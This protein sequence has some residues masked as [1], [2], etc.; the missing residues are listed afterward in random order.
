[1]AARPVTD[2][3]TSEADLRAELAELAKR[4]RAAE[5]RAAAAEKKA[6]VMADEMAELRERL[7]R[8][9][10]S[11]TE[12]SFF[13]DSE[14]N[15]AAPEPTLGLG[16]DGTDPRVTS[17]VLAATAVV[18]G[19]VTLLAFFNGNLMRPFGLGMLALTIGLA[20]AAA[21]TRVEPVQV[22]ISNGVV[23]GAS[24]GTTYRFDLKS[25]GTQ[26]DMTGEPG[27]AYWQVRF[28]RRHM[29]PFVVDADMVEPHG[30]VTQLRHY[31]P[32]L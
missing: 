2:S 22:S 16:R 27:D 4:C 26:I 1:M 6:E 17:L 25:D 30:F 8:Q 12:L 23:Y 14:P 19:M 32:S 28:M 31:R 5:Q 21:R 29:E 13:G 9:E 7:A 18:S 11:A 20:W 24:G 15:H 10:A 3:M